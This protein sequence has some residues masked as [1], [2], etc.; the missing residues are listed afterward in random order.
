MSPPR[1]LELV[2]MPLRA[3]IWTRDFRET[4]EGHGE[5]FSPSEQ[6][7]A[8]AGVLP[9]VHPRTDELARATPGLAEHQRQRHVSP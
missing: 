1:A 2:T 9:T 8:L 6:R 3:Q 4:F 5:R 7:A